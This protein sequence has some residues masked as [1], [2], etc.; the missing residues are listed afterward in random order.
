MVVVFTRYRLVIKL[1]T[2]K[3]LGLD[4]PVQL[5][6]V[7]DEV[8]EWVAISK[9]VLLRCMSPQV[10]HFCLEGRRAERGSSA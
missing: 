3:T 10:A 2:A 1:N 7:V 8:V 9:V 6:P 5:H 4:V